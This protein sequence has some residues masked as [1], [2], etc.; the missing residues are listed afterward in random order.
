[1][2]FV[3]KLAGSLS[4]EDDAASDRISCGLSIQNIDNR[5]EH[6][7]ANVEKRSHI[8]KEST[9]ALHAGGLLNDAP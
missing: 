5:K 8:A 1:V 3:V 4:I 2:A 7:D 6:C 9:P